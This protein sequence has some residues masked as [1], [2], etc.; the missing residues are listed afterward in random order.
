MHKTWF[1]VLALLLCLRPSQA[2]HVL[3]RQV[4]D[5]VETKQGRYAVFS[6]DN[7]A[8]F[9]VR[10]GVLLE[11]DKSLV[12]AVQPTRVLLRTADGKTLILPLVARHSAPRTPLAEVPPQD[13]LP[14]LL[15][16][17]ISNDSP[18]E[19]LRLLLLA[20]ALIH[21]FYQG[22]LPLENA[23]N[24]GHSMS[25]AVLLNQG[26]DVNAR[27]PGGQT[28]LHG[29]VRSTYVDKETFQ[30]LLDRGA[31]ANAADRDGETPLHQAAIERDSFDTNYIARLH[32]L[33]AYGADINRR[34]KWGDTP[35]HS[36]VEEG[37][38]DMMQWL[39]QNG[40]DVNRKNLWGDLPIHLAMRL[41]LANQLP[42]SSLS[43]AY[44]DKLDSE[45]LWIGRISPV[46]AAQIEAQLVF[47]KARLDVPD[48][49][50]LTPL[51]YALLNHDSNAVT[52][53]LSHLTAHERLAALFA[54]VALGNTAAL[55]RGLTA[56]A[57]L[58]EARGPR[59]VSLLHIAALWDRSEAAAF[60]LAHGADSNA[61][62]AEGRTTLHDACLGAGSGQM[63]RLLLTHGAHL[64][65]ED[66]HSATPLS[67]AVQQR[68]L[69]TVRFLLAA[70]AD[71]TVR[72]QTTGELAA[73]RN[74]AAYKIVQAL[75]E[76]G[77]DPNRMGESY[78]SLLG[79][80]VQANNTNFVWLLLDHGASLT[81]PQMRTVEDSLLFKALPVAN[82]DIIRMLLD[83]GAD[84]TAKGGSGRTALMLAAE[85]YQPETALLL[86]DHGADA[87][88][89]DDGGK[90]ALSYALPWFGYSPPPLALTPA[91]AEL[92][93]RL[94]EKGADVNVLDTQGN[95]LL[96]D[97][98]KGNLDATRMAIIK[99]MIMHGADVN[100]KDRQ[101]YTVLMQL[102]WNDWPG[103]RSAQHAELVRWL[104]SHG[105][106]IYA[107]SQN[108]MTASAF[109]NLPSPAESPEWETLRR[110][111]L[112]T[113][114]KK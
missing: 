33:R 20:P 16:N 29:A 4:T 105:A 30:L 78:E 72:L 11:P 3:P 51:W 83:H 114:S 37:N 73:N 24:S 41:P 53:L 18:T 47:H 92:I 39:L 50:G 87:T 38:V 100:A 112:K 95:P 70:G 13:Q 111:L 56:N 103:A 54:A 66:V 101:G 98:V 23:V 60:L 79:R 17:A 90:T 15:S 32:L 81:T 59:G 63:L 65:A 34:D 62:D 6:L 86:L 99:E 19:V 106:D 109:L 10:R 80:A 46:T 97:V 89:K 57:A 25:I 21:T 36:A 64:D 85:S 102:I 31:D 91:R 108:G 61:R 49:F 76:A 52:L 43:S 5:I 12:I 28:T 94:L 7:Q 110:S 35:L 74:H 93:R 45:R 44:A 14:Q 88:A 2:Q 26:A 67:L 96:L 22:Q 42:R 82:P 55:A 69:D 71:P 107:K 104:L 9:F 1:F 48:R 77:G 68:N 113:D 58:G 27:D 40:A 75:L 84:F 8:P